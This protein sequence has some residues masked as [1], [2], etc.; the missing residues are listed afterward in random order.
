M[1]QSSFIKW[2]F[3][4]SSIFLKKYWKIIL[5]ILSSY[6]KVYSRH[7]IL[8]LA[9]L[10]KII[11]LSIELTF[12]KTSQEYHQCVSLVPDHVQHFIEPEPGSNS[13]QRLSATT[14]YVTIFVVTREGK[15]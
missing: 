13:C 2:K 10:L 4:E 11:Q 14:K 1:L 15:S 7:P 8:H 3:L 5:K 6:V 12:S 9:N